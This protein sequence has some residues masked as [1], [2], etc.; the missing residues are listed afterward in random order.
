[1]IEVLV[2]FIWPHAPMSPSV[3]D[4]PDDEKQSVEKQLTDIRGELVRAQSDAIRFRQ[5]LEIDGGW[6]QA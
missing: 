2:R 6:P 4:I 1:M 3:S 5:L